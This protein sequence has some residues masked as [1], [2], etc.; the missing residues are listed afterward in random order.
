[1][2]AGILLN[3]ATGRYHPIIFRP[4]PMPGG[5]IASMS[6]QRYRSAGH[7]TT[8]F[9]TLAEAEAY[10]TEHPE[11]TAT[12]ATWEWDGEGAPALTEWLAASRAEAAS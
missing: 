10:I 6:A 3:T 8:G 7:H 11:W 2:H 12:G 1:M 9:A 4:A 5:A